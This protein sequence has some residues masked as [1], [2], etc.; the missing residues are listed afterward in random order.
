MMARRLA[1]VVA[2]AFAVSILAVGTGQAVCDPHCAPKANNGV[3]KLK[4]LDR[5]DDVAGGGANG[6]TNARE[7]QGLVP[8]VTTP[9]DGDLDGVPDADDRC[10]TEKGPASNGGCPVIELP[11]PGA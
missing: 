11:P 3:D 7:K 1:L 9:P 5:A 2:G 4:G 8:V 10:L 6:R